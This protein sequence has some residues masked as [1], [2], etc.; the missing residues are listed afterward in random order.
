MDL[1]LLTGTVKSQLGWGDMDEFDFIHLNLTKLVEKSRRQL[2]I[3]TWGSEE[4]ASRRCSKEFNI[5]E[6]EVWFLP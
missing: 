3:R 6:R 4:R 5:A 2:E 1:V